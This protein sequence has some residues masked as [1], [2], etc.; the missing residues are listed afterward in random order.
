MTGMHEFRNGVTHTMNPRTNL[1]KGAVTLPDLLKTAGYRNGFIDKWHIGS[2]RNGSGYGP[3]DRGFDW[4]STTSGGVRVFF[5][6]DVI[7]NE[8]R[9]PRKGFREDIYFDEA[10]AFIDETRDQPFFATFLLTRPIF[11]FERRRNVYIRNSRVVSN[12]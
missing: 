4:S 7:R 9:S 5:D 3:K 8:H 12:L 10:M 6:P 1:F 11:R 2:N